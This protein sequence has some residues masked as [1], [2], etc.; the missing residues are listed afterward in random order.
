M[1]LIGPGLKSIVLIMISKL[2]IAVL[3]GDAKHCAKEAFA[4]KRTPHIRVH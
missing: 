1:H 2:I 4:V 3:R